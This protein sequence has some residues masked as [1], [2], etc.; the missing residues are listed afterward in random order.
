[1]MTSTGFGNEVEEE[2]FAF[3]DM[4][5]GVQSP[6]TL[7]DES[8]SQFDIMRTP[9]SLP[10]QDDIE[11][12]EYTVLP[13]DAIPEL[14]PSADKVDA[15][16]AKQMTQL[17]MQDREKVYYDLHGISGE[18]KE[19]PE[20]IANSL[21]DLEEEIQKQTGKEAY[22]TARSMNPEYVQDEKFLLQFLRADLFDA[23]KTALRLVRHFQTKLDLF[24]RDKLARNIIQDDLDEGSMEAL[25]G[26][27]TQTMPFRDRAGRIITV[28]FLSN[29]KF[30][31]L[32]V[33]AK[34]SSS[35]RT[36]VP[37]VLHSLTLMNL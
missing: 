31:H 5:L 24:G 10:P 25:Y 27:L 21:I 13:G 20:M 37:I 26:G 11:D 4:I 7:R 32:S 34:V 3:D 22:E 16:I 15:L 9:E 23:K 19:T 14:S 36:I 17:S 33:E 8:E 28:W 18:I 12:E 30:Y 1:M 29:D 6:D 35:F 2:E